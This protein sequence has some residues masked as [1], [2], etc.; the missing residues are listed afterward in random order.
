MLDDHGFETYEENEFPLAYLI[1]FRTYG[2]WLHG[3]E[4]WSVRRNALG[5]KEYP[6]NLPFKDLTR[7]EMDQPPVVL[8][9]EQRSVVVQAVTE[10]CKHRSYH[11]HAINARS[12][13]VHAVVSAA[14]KPE[15]IADT[16]KAYSTR[17]LRETVPI[18]TETKVWS[19]GRS[20]RYLW[21]PGHVDAAVSYTLYSQGDEAFVQDDLEG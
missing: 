17:R 3:D 11:L 19:R 15:R 1:T 4:R 13:H 14:L 7:D 10:V 21:K 5:P 18:S 12:N 2:T 16:F 6:P 9:D 20:R 8:E